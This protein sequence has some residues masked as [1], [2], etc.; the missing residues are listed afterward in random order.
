M[1]SV[2]APSVTRD[3]LAE[4]HRYCQQL[5]KRTAGNFYYTFLTLP[6]DRF[7]AM[8]ALYAFMR[9]TD[10]LGDSDEPLQIRKAALSRWRESLALALADGV[11]D[12]PLHPA[13]VDVLRTYQVPATYLN[14]VIAGV[15][16]DL[17][18]VVFATF[19]DLE[20]YC[21]HV[22]GAVG[23]ACIHIWGFHDERAKGAATDCGLAFQLTNILR[24]LA[25]DAEVGRTYLPEEDLIRFGYGTDDIVRKVRDDRFTRLMQFETDRARDY[26]ARAN[27]LVGYLNPPGKP[28]FEAMLG[29]YGGLLE[30][31]IRRKFDVYSSRVRLSRWRKTY[32]AARAI[33]GHRLR[34]LW[35]RA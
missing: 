20:R 14:D 3:V 15:E 28:I 19:A 5:A 8:C 2:P 33:I 13:L 17:G 16:M 21:Y 32:I 12:H 24:D 11:G 7:Q 35:S 31:I 25:E 29:I 1:S 22:A 27:R 18:P 34:S 6:R 30:T 23:L 9:V 26:Y 4:S 10:D